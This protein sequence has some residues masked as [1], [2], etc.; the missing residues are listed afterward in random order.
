[1]IWVHHITLML[2]YNQVKRPRLVIRLLLLSM[3][4]IELPME[5]KDMNYWFPLMI[6][7]QEL[8]EARYNLTLIGSLKKNRRRNN[9]AL[10]SYMPQTNKIVMLFSSKQ[11]MKLRVSQTFYTVM[12]KC[13]LALTLLANYLSK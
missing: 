3:G 12:M 8:P 4:K 6:Y 10:L 2:V 1:M 9:K 7:A 13:K 5:V 11:E